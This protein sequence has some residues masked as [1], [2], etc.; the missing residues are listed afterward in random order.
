[1]DSHHNTATISQRERSSDITR[2]QQ[3]NLNVHGFE[4]EKQQSEDVLG[5]GDEIKR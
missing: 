4:G 2:N 3:Y 1:M 5:G